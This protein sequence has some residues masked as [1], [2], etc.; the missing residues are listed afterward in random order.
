MD[1]QKKVAAPEE[2]CRRVPSIPG[3]P[4][5]TRDPIRETAVGHQTL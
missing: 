5:P 2:W 1:C 4:Q 3:R